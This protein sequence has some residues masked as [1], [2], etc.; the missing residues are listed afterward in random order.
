[1]EWIGLK[2]YCCH[3]LALTYTKMTI[4]ELKIGYVRIYL[5]Y[6]VHMYFKKSAKWIP[7][8][9]QC[10]M[11]P[12]WNMCYASKFRSLYDFTREFNQDWY[13]L[14]SAFKKETHENLLVLHDLLLMKIRYLLL[15]GPKKISLWWTIMHTTVLSPQIRE[16]ILVPDI[17]IYT[18]KFEFPQ[19]P[20]NIN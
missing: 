8:A 2:L 12:C 16:Q 15:T 19:Q 18:L 11:S 10:T 3:A 6:S 13:F 5:Q 4:S 9:L 17:Y 1:M 20:I 7:F 14:N